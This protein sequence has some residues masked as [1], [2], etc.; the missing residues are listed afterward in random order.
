MF[1]SIFC[2]LSCTTTNETKA[3]DSTN[4]DMESNVSA[5]MSGALITSNC[6]YESYTYAVDILLSCGDERFDEVLRLHTF[7]RHAWEHKKV[8]RDQIRTK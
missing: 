8:F 2:V 3:L 5:E 4:P 1:V 6:M 7:K